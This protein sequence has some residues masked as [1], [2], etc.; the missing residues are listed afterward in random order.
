MSGRGL[1]SGLFFGGF[2]DVAEAPHEMFHAREPLGDRR[3][4]DDEGLASG[5][6]MGRTEQPELAERRVP[7]L[8]VGFE[9]V[10]VGGLQGIPP[11]AR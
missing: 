4:I 8:G 2:A 3:S 11:R 6:A 10:D 5:D 9:G 7:I 1:G